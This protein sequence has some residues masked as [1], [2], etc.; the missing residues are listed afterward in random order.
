LLLMTVLVVWMQQSRASAPAAPVVASGVVPEPESGFSITARLVLRM[1][2]AVRDLDAQATPPGGA[3]PNAASMEANSGAMMSQLD[4][5]A[6]TPAERLRLAITAGEL[7]GAGSA[8]KILDKLESDLKPNTAEDMPPV[9]KLDDA[10]RGQLLD[11]VGTVRA[12]LDKQDV[13][14][15]QTQALVDRHGWFGKLAQV[16]GKPSSDPAREQLL[17]G[18]LALLLFLMAIGL[19]AIA[20][21]VA[22]V[23]CFV[24]WFI[25][26]ASGRR[27]P[28]AF[29]PP[30]P[31]GSVY[32]ETVAAFV[33]AFLALRLVS[34]FVFGALFTPGNEPAWLETATLGLQWL[35]LPSIFYPMLRGVSWSQWKQDMG[36][37]TGRGV[38]REIGSGIFAYLAGFPLVIGAVLISMIAMMIRIAMAGGKE[39]PSPS[40]PVVDIVT[41]GDAMTLVL[42]YSLVSIWAPVVEESIF[43]GAL[44]RHLRSRMGVIAAAVASALL[45]GVMHGYEWMLLS[46]VIALGLIFAMMRDQRGSLIAPVVMHALHNGIL[47]ACMLVV[48]KLSGE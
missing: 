7:Q 23:V 1:M 12:I 11:D 16:H 35:V 18:G 31:G 19:G 46:P 47:M 15:G 34:T 30:V 13:A 36:W 48:L 9:Y 40:N 27:P 25:R 33:A 4:P 20:L 2:T 28:H 22:S 8:T 43:R 5:V 24:I 41:S 21:F 6:R 17:S 44:F 14:P 42:L 37:H 26:S 45:F 29:E 38:F 32:L 3:S 39:P 10:V